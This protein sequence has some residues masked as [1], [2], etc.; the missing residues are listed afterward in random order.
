LVLFASAASDAPSIRAIIDAVKGVNALPG[1]EIVVGGGVFNRADGLAEEIGAS[2][3]A[4]SPAHLVST[5]Q[6]PKRE[7]A[8]SPVA[9]AAKQRSM[10]AVA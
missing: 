7:I 3:V 5:L 8:C 10:R 4:K 6:E 1:M 9:S 2:R